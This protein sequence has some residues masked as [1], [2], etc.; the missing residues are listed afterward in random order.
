MSKYKLFSRINLSSIGQSIRS[1]INLAGLYRKR[2]LILSIVGAYVLVGGL[3]SYFFFST[4]YD[5]AKATDEVAKITPVIDLVENESKSYSLGDE[6]TIKLTLQNNSNVESINNLTTDLITTKNSVSWNTAQSTTSPNLPAIERKNDEFKLPILSSGERAVYL[7]TGKIQNLDGNFLTIVAKV[8]Y[9]NSE[10]RQEVLSNKVF[11]QF[12]NESTQ[13]NQLL[14][15]TTSKPVFSAGEEIAFSLDASKNPTTDVAEEVFGKI[16]ISNSKASQNSVSLDCIINLDGFCS[17]TT[18]LEES[19]EYTALFITNDGLTY[20]N[21]LTLSI[22]GATNPN[23][24]N[25]QG[26]LTFPFDSKSVN[27]VVPVI[28]TRVIGFNKIVEPT[29][30][31]VFEILQ[32]GG[33]V[34]E[35]KTSVKPDRTCSTLINTAQ[36]PTGEGIYTV[37]LRGTTAGKDVSFLR[38]SQNLITLTSPSQNQV[39]GSQVEISSSLVNDISSSP[40]KFDPVTLTI[41]H[42]DSGEVQE[43][44]SI[45][46]NQLAI[47]DGV[48][49]ATVPSTYF[50]KGGVYYAFITSQEG[51]SSEFL[52]INYGSKKTGLVYSGV[53]VDNYQNLQ[54]GKNMSFSLQ[55]ITDTNGNTMNGGSCSALLYTKVSNSQPLIIDSSI[56]NGNCNVFVEAGKIKTSGPIVVS[57]SGE[58]I[59]NGISQARSFT[60][61]PAPVKSYGQLNLEISPPIKGY[62]NTLILGPLADE[63][64]NSAN[65]Y[66]LTAEIIVNDEVIKKFEGINTDSGFAKLTIP[67]SILENEKIKIRLVDSS[68]AEVIAREFITQP[69]TNK[70]PR[71]LIDSVVSNDS[72]IHISLKDVELEDGKSCIIKTLTPSGEIISGEIPYLK[73]SKSCSAKW[74]LSVNRNNKKILVMLEAGSNLYSKTVELTNGESSN[75]FTINPAMHIDKADEINISLITSI[76]T[77]R[78]GLLV[79]NGDLKLKYNG[80]IKEAKILNGIAKTQINSN[81]ITSKDLRKSFD[82]SYLELNI[83]ASASSNS[84]SKTNYLDIFLGS[85]PLATKS[86]SL[87]IINAKSHITKDSQH[88]FAFKSEICSALLLSNDTLQARK[89]KTHHQLN[90]CFVE[91][92]E[93]TSPSTIIFEDKGNVI[94]EFSV[95]PTLE[96]YTSSQCTKSPCI[97]QIKAPIADRLEATIYDGVNQYVTRGKDLENTITIEN[98]NLNAIDSYLVKITFTNNKGETIEYYSTIL[99]EYLISKQN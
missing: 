22:A 26:N 27:G 74:D 75:L 65:T 61:A 69:D 79:N 97:M 17:A 9:V 41:F 99:G 43:A 46:G 45:N 35:I 93:L 1:S 89:L 33:V 76:I 38:K 24:T 39:I 67:S 82:T 13:F 81:D 63:Y 20:S 6:V 5:S 94:G 87:Q 62:A 95:S 29:D 7:I 31:C 52:T 34:T 85:K 25:P 88:I 66:N 47:V 40:I 48:F 51:R 42:E 86:E 70:A 49:S 60:I 73:E 57:F 77:D 68:G 23:Q 55:N 16:F 64:G 90:T 59:A 44:S 58:G 3:L 83:D 19:G 56:Q 72:P 15:L 50:Q 10:G 98:S 4:D 14:Q 78:Y 18:K 53:L 32:G 54:V 36:I 37:R 12:N 2:F 11:T 28:A 96:N 84:I 92:S 71:P 30:V 21:I 91:L 8:N 80:K